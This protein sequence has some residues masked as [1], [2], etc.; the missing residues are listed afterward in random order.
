[1]E[2][3]R[4]LCLSPSRPTRNRVNR[5]ICL[6]S[7][8]KWARD[9]RSPELLGRASSSNVFAALVGMELWS[10]HGRTGHHLANLASVLSSR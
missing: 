9:Q 7:S 3:R 8:A 4:Q 5:L 2:S 6:W 1:M 10:R